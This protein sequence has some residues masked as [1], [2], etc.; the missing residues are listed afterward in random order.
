[1]SAYDTILR[2]ALAPHTDCE[3]NHLPKPVIAS[4]YHK[5]VDLL[6]DPER[7]MAAYR[8]AIDPLDLHIDYACDDLERMVVLERDK[9]AIAMHI[10]DTL[11]GSLVLEEGADH[12]EV[13]PDYQPYSMW[14]FLRAAVA[15]YILFV[16]AVHSS[17]WIA[18]R[19]GLLGG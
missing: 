6:D 5:L 10:A 19:V 8:Q 7:L 4:S 9:K 13:N 14:I 1:M 11:A 15:I 18:V 3:E 17:L 2:L 12:P 16:L